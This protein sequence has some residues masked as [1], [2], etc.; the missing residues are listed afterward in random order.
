MRS[1]R[2]RCATTP[3][4]ARFDANLLVLPAIQDENFFEWAPARVLIVTAAFRFRGLGR[5]GDG[6]F[7]KLSYLFRL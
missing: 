4:F 1:F 6:F 7:L 2:I 3:Q 5:T